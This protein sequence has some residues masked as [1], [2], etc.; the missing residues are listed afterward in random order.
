VNTHGIGK[1]PPPLR[2]LLAT[3]HLQGWTGSETLLLTLVEGL[4]ESGVH[5]VVYARYLDFAWA[6]S[7]AP[8]GVQFSDDL[9]QIQHLAFDVAHVQ[10]NNCLLDVRS[11]FPC[12]PIIF[13]SLGVLPFLEQPVPFELGVVRH[14]AISEEVQAHLIAQGVSADRIEILRNLVCSRRFS[15]KHAIQPRPRHILTVSYKMDDVRKS[16]LRSAA[17]SIGASIRFVGGAESLTQNELAA[18]INQADI[19]VTIGRGVIE[20]M[21]CGR[22]P[23]VYDIHGGDGLVTPDNLES[24]RTCNFSGRRHGKDYTLAELL[25]EFS[26]YRSDFGEELRSLAEAQYALSTHLP[27]VLRL[28]GQMACEN[29]SVPTETLRLATFAA[30]LARQDLSRYQEQVRLTHAQTAELQRVKRSFSWRI[31]R[32]LRYFWN[33]WQRLWNQAH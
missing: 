5:I 29:V 8:A 23:L 25:E 27:T 19:V 22:V 1:S 7:L 4:H 3:N 21:L 30:T 10:H 12:L 11:A 17:D 6:Q 9:K 15:P 26:K 24:L 2:L 14:L 32:P 18:A 20:A 33:S 28:Y 31:T 13:S 16:L